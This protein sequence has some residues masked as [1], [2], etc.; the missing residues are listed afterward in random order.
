MVCVTVKTE[1]SALVPEKLGGAM[2]FAMC[3]QGQGEHVP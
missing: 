1:S 3:Q 2:N